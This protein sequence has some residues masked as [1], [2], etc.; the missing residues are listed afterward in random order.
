MR[1][2]NGLQKLLKAGLDVK[3]NDVRVVRRLIL[4]ACA[5]G[6]LNM[7]FTGNFLHRYWSTVK[8]LIMGGGV[9]T[10]T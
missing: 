3:L 9:C 8:F 4:G 2:E 6:I 5:L 1:L 10:L 7:S